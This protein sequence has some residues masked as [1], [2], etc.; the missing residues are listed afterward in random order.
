MKRRI[1]SILAVCCMMVAMMP[2][3]FATGGNDLQAQIDNTAAGG[4]VTLTGNVTISTPLTINKAITLD[5]NGNTLT[6]DQSG[7]AIKITTNDNV[8]I[9]DMIL[10][11]E[12]SNG[13]GIS[14]YSSSPKVEVNGVTMNVDARGISF[15]Q[16]GYA[17]NAHLAL[18]NTKIYNSRITDGDYEHKTVIGDTR[19]ISLFDMK[20]SVID[21]NN[22]EIYGFG[23]TINLAGTLVDGIRDYD[24][25]TV[26]VTDSKLMGWTAFNVWSSDTTFNITNSYLKGINNSNGP[27]DGFATIVVNDDIYGY[28]WGSTKANMFYITGGTITNYRSG[29]A[30]E[31]LFRVDDEG[32]TEVT[33]SELE[34]DEWTTEKVTIIDGTGDSNSVFYSG[35]LMTPDGWIN[36]MTQRVHGEG[37]CEVTGYNG[38]TLPFIPA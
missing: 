4:T 3:A 28:G 10:N 17:T 15:K 2:A 26:N 14:L 7:E 18:D 5:G 37:S 23:Y 22:S 25:T 27:T 13:Q 21:I 9:E 20:S 12:A 24:G 34:V 33:F 16:D 31:Q 36:Y 8:V 1:I 38:Q 29:S 11:A 30:S 6:Y 35:Y 19:G 32:I